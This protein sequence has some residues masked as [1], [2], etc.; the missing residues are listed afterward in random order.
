[1]KTLEYYNSTINEIRT[2]QW[3][4]CAEQMPSGYGDYLVTTVE[5]VVTVCTFSSEDS[6]PVW[7]C[8]YGDEGLMLVSRDEIIAWAVLPTPYRP[9]SRK[10][11]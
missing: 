5:G 6:T 1:M 7:W 11:H 3:I 4:P 9:A 10:N 8:G 2:I